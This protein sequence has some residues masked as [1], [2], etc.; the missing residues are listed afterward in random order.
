[1]KAQVTL[2]TTRTRTT[3]T[4]TVKQSSSSKQAIYVYI[5]VDVW[6][7]IMFSCIAV[8]PPASGPII[9]NS[10]PSTTCTAHLLL[11]CILL[12]LQFTQRWWPHTSHR[13]HII[14]TSS[15][16]DVST[17]T[18]LWCCKVVGARPVP[19]CWSVVWFHSPH[20]CMLHSSSQTLL[21]ILIQS[22][23]HF[24][25]FCCTSLHLIPQYMLVHWHLHLY[26][27]VTTMIWVTTC[28]F[29]VTMVESDF[30]TWVANYLMHTVF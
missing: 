11:A 9:G 3:T 12:L 13:T 19:T 27:C 15:R 4:T 21:I 5:H 16:G 24:L 26:V 8:E 29:F 18:C 7:I 20:S 2:T 23:Y 6:W 30:C 14:M 28:L 1:M 22:A 17:G 25:T 10:S